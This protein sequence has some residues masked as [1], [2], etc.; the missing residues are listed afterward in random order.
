MN[1]EY[2]EKYQVIKADEGMVLTEWKEGD[3]ILN[4]S[5]ASMQISPL[6]YD[7]SILREITIEESDR[8]LKE[9]EEALEAE[10]EKE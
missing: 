2:K 3:D 10:R 1:I 9:Q 4:Y 5:F 7:A 8:L 6:N